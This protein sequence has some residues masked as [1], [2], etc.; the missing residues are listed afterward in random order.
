MKEYKIVFLDNIA[1]LKITAEDIEVI[2]DFIKFKTA[3]RV[4]D[5][6]SITV[7]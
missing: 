5:I 1:E 3:Y 7:A 6:Y 4:Q 2:I